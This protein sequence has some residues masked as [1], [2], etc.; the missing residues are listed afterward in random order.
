MSKGQ[1]C[2]SEEPGSGE[3]GDDA[4]EC[5]QRGGAQRGRGGDEFPI[6]RRKRSCERLDGE[7]QAINNRADDESGKGECES[8]AGERNPP[9]TQRAPRPQSDQDIEA[10][11]SWRMHDG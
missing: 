1:G 11:D 5:T 10:E 9:A 3:W 2:A 6:D 8:V 7:R 4:Q